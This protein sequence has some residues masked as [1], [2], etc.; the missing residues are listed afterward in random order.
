MYDALNEVSSVTSANK[1]NRIGVFE[2]GYF[3]SIE[4]ANASPKLTVELKIEQSNRNDIEIELGASETTIDSFNNIDDK[5]KFYYF[6]NSQKGNLNHSGTSGTSTARIFVLDYSKVYIDNT[7]KYWLNVTD[8]NGTANNT[9]VNYVKWY[10]SS[11]NEIKSNN[12]SY[13]INASGKVYDSA[14]PVQSVSLNKTNETLYIN[15]ESN[16]IHTILPTNA[17]NKKV[18]WSSSNNNVATVDE[19]GNVKAVGKGTAI[20]TVNALDGSGKTASCTYTVKKAVSNIVINGF[21]ND[22]YIKE[23]NQL[24]ATVYPADADDLS[25]KWTSS[26][27]NVVKVSASGLVTCVGTGTAV[28]RVEAKDGRGAYAECT[29]T[30][31]DDFS[32]IAERAYEVFLYDSISGEI[33]EVYDTDVFKFTP[34]E[35]GIYTIFT[36]GD[37]DT[38]CFI[39][40]DEDLL[41]Y[42]AVDDESGVY[43]NFAHKIQ[44]VAGKTYY[45]EVMEFRDGTGPYT[46][47]ISKNVLRVDIPEKN[48]DARHV[49]IIAEASSLYDTLELYIGSAIYKITKPE[50]GDYDATFGNVRIKVSFEY[51]NNNTVLIWRIVA[52]ITPTEIGEVDG[53]GFVFYSEDIVEVYE[54][55]IGIVAYKSTVLTGVEAGSKLVDLV[56]ELDSSDEYELAIKNWDNSTLVYTSTDCARTGL[57]IIKRDIDTGKI[58]EIYYLVIYGDVTGGDQVGDGYVTAADQLAVLQDASKTKELTGTA[59]LAADVNHDGIIDASD[60]LL[61]SQCAAKLNEIDQDYEITVVPDDCYYLDPVAF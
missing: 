53:V 39:Y 56:T 2:G 36:E 54:T 22:L 14:Y 31:T 48:P 57:K 58:V 5:N 50:T 33:N 32:S 37:T 26:N 9:K 25:V 6:I 45:I 47:K 55:R 41:D 16:L 4:V 15:D 59:A 17:T 3:F 46:L 13:A 34:S 21:N 35:T 10:D 1:A 20:I 49:D 52:R 18:S 29:Y 30:I 38:Y 7:T 40:D 51:A 42:I 44:L 43:E 24:S 60:A 28:I 19:S 12:T 27:P 23:T 8:I 11:Y 61:I